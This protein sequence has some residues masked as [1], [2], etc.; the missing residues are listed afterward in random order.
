M[1]DDRDDE[2]DEFVVL[3]AFPDVTSAHLAAGVLESA[4]IDVKFADEY[5]AS[6]YPMGAVVG[7]VKLFVRRSSA[8]DADAILRQTA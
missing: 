6:F 7:G 1:T 4:G 3:R 5:A 8:A 2:S